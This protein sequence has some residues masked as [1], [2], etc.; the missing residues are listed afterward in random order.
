MLK[1]SNSWAGKRA[2]QVQLLVNTSN[3]S[4][5]PRTH[6]VE[7]KNQ[8][9]E[10][11]L[12]IPQAHLHSY[13][14]PTH[15]HTLNILKSSLSV[16]SQRS[17]VPLDTWVD[18]PAFCSSPLCQRTPPVP[19]SCW[20]WSLSSSLSLILT[21]WAV[22]LPLS[23]WKLSCLWVIPGRVT[24]VLCFHVFPHCQV[25]TPAWKPKELY[26]FLWGKWVGVSWFPGYPQTLYVVEEDLS[27]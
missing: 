18:W 25:V 8:L 11:A 17:S 20:P 13:T 24:V 21:G 23:W 5:I 16:S 2:Q 7:G 4:A 1:K 27:D 3:L 10:V 9:Q 12:W 6:M 14:P 19:L 15:T 22:Q 26:L